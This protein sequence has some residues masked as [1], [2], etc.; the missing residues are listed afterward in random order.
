MDVSPGYDAHLVFPDSITYGFSGRWQ[1]E[2]TAMVS[3][4]FA[5]GLAFNSWNGYTEGMDVVPTVEY[6]ERFYFWLLALCNVVIG[7][8]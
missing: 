2:F 5:D 7:N 4:F 1:N 6:S 3:T 8:N